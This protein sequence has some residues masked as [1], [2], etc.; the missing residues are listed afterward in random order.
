[1]RTSP[2]STIALVISG[3]TL[4]R[5]DYIACE[6][7]A[8]C[9]DEF[10]YG[11]SCNSD[12]FCEVEA[13]SERCEL[14]PDDVTFPISKDEFVLL[15]TLFDHSLDTHTGRYR[16]A[17]LALN[18]A[19]QNGG[20]DG[21]ELAALHC[22]NEDG[23]VDGL[24]KDEATV[25]LA[26]WMADPVGLKAIV[27][28]S[29]SSRTE[30]AYIALTELDTLLI[31]PSATS[32]S[33]TDLD[34]LT[35]SN[36]SPGMLW[37]TAPPDSLQGEVIADDMLDR[38]SLQVAVIYQTGAY[39]EGLETVFTAS[40]GARGG[41]SSGFPF[42]SE[43]DRSDAITDAGAGDFDEV[44]FISSDSE[45]IIAFLNS[46]ALLEGYQDVPIFLTDSAR[47]ADV[48]ENAAEAEALF[49]LLRGTAPS[50]P[51]GAVYEAF[52]VSYASE[53][54]GEDVS[55]YSYTANAFDAAW[56]LIYGS[57]WSLSQEGALSGVGIARGLR[58]LSYGDE[59]EVR[60]SYWNTIK[61]HLSEGQSVDISGASGEL[62]FDSETEETTAPI[63]IWVINSSGD[64]FE[65]IDTIYP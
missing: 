23:I 15:G 17:Q 60:S 56:M 44:L 55:I 46:A 59:V 45:D 51:S 61:A 4:S 10:G 54:A 63:D 8:V 42:T 62:D 43:S 36:D 2:F 57:V 16:S 65:V 32:P 13:L 38:E 35:A 6:S 53:Y 28:P 9:Q 48:L 3:C 50:L 52:Q 49:P 24:T 30:A 34:G 40:F 21:L 47:N 11:T 18:Q 19:N 12:G 14:W 22:N 33:L 27:G 31:S 25:D 7:S 37:R 41:D 39:G 58:R 64:D 26:V 29:S 20:L 5:S 1:M